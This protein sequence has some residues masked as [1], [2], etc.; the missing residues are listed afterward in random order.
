LPNKTPTPESAHFNGRFKLTIDKH[1]EI[2]F[3]RECSGLSVQVD[4][5]EVK[6]GGQNQ[7]THKLPG[8]MKWPNIVLKRGISNTNELFDWFTKSSG[9]GFSG[10]QNKLERSSGCIELISSDGKTVRIWE[11][12]D[13]FPVKWTGPTLAASA[14]DVAGEELEIAHHGFTSS[15]GKG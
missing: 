7:F 13:A 9:D 11:F 5:E 12:Y 8:R 3:W 14:K 2:G 6:E 4:V 10:N 1:Q 15:S